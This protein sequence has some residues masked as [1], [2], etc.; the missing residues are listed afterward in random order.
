MAGDLDYY[1]AERLAGE[2]AQEEMCEDYC[3]DRF[4]DCPDD[5]IW[6]LA[7][8]VKQ[9]LSQEEFLAWCDQ[10]RRGLAWVEEPNAALPPDAWSLLRVLSESRVLL[11]GQEL[12][13]RIGRDRKTVSPILRRLRET[14]ITCYPEGPRKGAAITEA[15][16]AKLDD[17]EKK[18]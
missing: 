4:L 13:S 7:D 2:R 16:R 11:T 18:S 10:V 17:A 14:G 8:E 15:G 6:W 9:R 5:T 12:A 1:E 3:I